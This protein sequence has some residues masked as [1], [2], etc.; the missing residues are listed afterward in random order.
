MNVNID[1]SQLERL[2]AAY[3]QMVA[4]EA[5]YLRLQDIQDELSSRERIP[6]LVRLAELMQSAKALFSQHPA[7]DSNQQV[8]RSFTMAIARRELHTGL[9]PT[10]EDCA[11]QC[12]Q[13]ASAFRSI[14]PQGASGMMHAVSAS[15]QSMVQ[16]L[17]QEAHDLIERQT[18]NEVR[19]VLNERLAA[20]HDQHTTVR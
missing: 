20:L 2:E 7:H 19:K 16:Q 12:E 10:A 14:A 8:I 18:V 1:L 9:Q 13:L 5:E 11:R 17:G 3:Q 6:V 4:L 15:T